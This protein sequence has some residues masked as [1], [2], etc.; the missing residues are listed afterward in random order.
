MDNN[1]VVYFRYVVASGILIRVCIKLK[2]PLAVWMSRN[3]SRYISLMFLQDNSYLK[4]SIDRKT[5]LRK[6]G[7]DSI[8]DTLKG[9]KVRSAIV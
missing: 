7:D 1:Y 4:I 2:Y 5:A 3:H 9:G 8:C 6:Y